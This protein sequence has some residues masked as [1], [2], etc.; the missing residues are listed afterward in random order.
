MQW[1]SPGNEDRCHGEDE[2]HL[3]PFRELFPARNEGHR[4]AEV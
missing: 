3:E 4:N 2:K 1:V